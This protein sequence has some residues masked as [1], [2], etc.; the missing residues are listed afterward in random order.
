MNVAWHHFWTFQ[1]IKC[2]KQWLAPVTFESIAEHREGKE[3]PHRN[4]AQGS[5]T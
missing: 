1:D 2:E 5:K 4:I 3:N